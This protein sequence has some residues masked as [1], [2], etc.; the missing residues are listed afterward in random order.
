[1][2]LLLAAKKRVKQ[3]RSYDSKKTKVICALELTNTGKIK[4]G[5]AKIIDNY[6][7]KA[8]KPLFEEHI[9]QTEAKIQT[10]Q[11]SAYKKLAKDYNIQQEK[12]KPN[13]NF[14]QMHTIIQQIKSGLRT[15]QTHVSKGHLQKYLDEYFYRLNRSI[16]KKTIFDTLFKKLVQHQPC[17]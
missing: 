5:Y 4:R 3:G 11:W 12:S 6:S 17:F 2:N 13:E 8:M 10:D 15:I 14:K 9:S 7:A 1:M 16:F